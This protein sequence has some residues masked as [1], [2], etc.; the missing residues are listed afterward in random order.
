MTKRL[1]LTVQW[2]ATTS[3]ISFSAY[4]LAMLASEDELY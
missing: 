2:Q 3:Q 4:V 1:V